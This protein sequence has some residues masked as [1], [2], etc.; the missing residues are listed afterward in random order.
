VRSLLDGAAA[1]ELRP[2][3]SCLCRCSDP[4]GR[5]QVSRLPANLFS[6]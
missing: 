3:F 4:I 2:T 6:E 5:R 1:S